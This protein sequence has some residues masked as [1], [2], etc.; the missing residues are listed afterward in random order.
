MEKDLRLAGLKVDPITLDPWRR[1]L[2]SSFPVGVFWPQMMITFQRYMYYFILQNVNG[3]NV[4]KLFHSLWFFD[5]VNVC[6]FFPFKTC[7]WGSFSSQRSCVSQ[8]AI[9]ALLRVLRDPTLSSYHHRVVGSLMYILK[10]SFWLSRCGFI[11][12]WYHSFLLRRWVFLT[13]LKLTSWFFFFFFLSFFDN[14]FP[15]RT[16]DKMSVVMFRYWLKS[17]G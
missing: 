10:V 17:E 13:T 1:F 4:F 12:I 15:S 14:F 8:V 2:L 5:E 11:R 6:L 16:L 3:A 7:N 9:K